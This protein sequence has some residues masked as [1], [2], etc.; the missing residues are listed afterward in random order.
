M[1]IINHM[2]D[3]QANRSKTDIKHTLLAVEKKK[4]DIINTVDNTCSFPCTL[5]LL[6][7][8]AILCKHKYTIL[9]L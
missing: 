5:K 6:K 7:I 4:L 8:F 3:K 2:I 9:S 1:Q